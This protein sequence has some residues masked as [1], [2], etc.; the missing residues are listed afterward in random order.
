MTFCHVRSTFP[1]GFCAAGLVPR[2]WH[3][4]RVRSSGRSRAGRLIAA[5]VVLLVLAGALFA[6]DRLAAAYAERRAAQRLEAYGFTAT[7]DVTIEGFPFLTQVASKRIGAVDISGSLHTSGVLMSVQ[8]RG[9]GIALG[10]SY[11]PTTVAAVSGSAQ[12]P[13]SSLD[14]LTHADDLPGLSLSAGPGRHTV[15]LRMD[16]GPLTVSRA[17]R[18][19]QPR[20]GKITIRLVSPLKLGGALGNLIPASVLARFRQFTIQLPPLPLGLTVGTVT[21]EHT[22]ALFT[23]SAHNVSIPASSS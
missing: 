8:G 10:P 11:R 18:V 3:H 23:V 22:G 19:S 1:T 6:A 16:L 9:T 12:I 5:T 15:E 4:G 7:P 20:G 13:F 14:V 2:T 17:A 21:V